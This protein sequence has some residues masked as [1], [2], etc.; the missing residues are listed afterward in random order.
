MDPRSW[1]WRQIIEFAGFM[2]CVM[3]VTIGTGRSGGR[4]CA[5]P[6]LTGALVATFALAT[7]AT[8]L[9][10]SPA[11]ADCQPN[12]A[13]AASGKTVNCP[14]N[15]PTGF[16]AGA[17]VTSLPVSVQPGATAH[18]NGTVAIGVNNNNTVTNNGTV[19]GG[20][21]IT[22]IQAFDNNT[23]TNNA[24][25]AVGDSGV[26][27]F[28]NNNSTVLNT[29][30]GTITAGNSGT[31]IQI[32]GNGSTIT[33][34]GTLTIGDL[35]I[36]IDMSGAS[37]TTA[38]NNGTIV[39][40]AGTGCCS[41]IGIFAGTG[42]MVVNNG[43]IA[44]GPGASGILQFGDSS[45]I[46]NNGIINVASG[47]VGVSLFG[48]VQN[49]VVNNGTIAV[50]DGAFGIIDF[51]GSAISNNGLITLATTL[52]LSPG[53]GILAGPG[54]TVTNN[55]AMAG[56]DNT[57]G[58]FTAGLSGTIVNNGTITVGAATLGSGSSAGIDASGAGGNTVINNGKITTGADGI[59]I[60]TGDSHIIH[61]NRMGIV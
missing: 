29:A 18:D 37:G 10:A 9:G 12:S 34:S 13:S 32:T 31:G 21:G 3:R 16:Q 23:V 19:T 38:V 27:I 30:T 49:T 52:G 55:G 25:I 28:G 11:R 51:G 1:G 6:A 54:S 56:G 39:V 5:V 57:I 26:G 8:L 4:R 22:G 58:I 2:G 35:G 43:S 14:G 41:G 60:A 36:G 50:G 7:F 46:T 20:A 40:G 48:G 61:H 44:A 33:N 15:A 45:I 53:I 59:G 17:G 42:G 24:A 47:G